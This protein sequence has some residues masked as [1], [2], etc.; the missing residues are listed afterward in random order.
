MTDKLMWPSSL[1]LK[2]LLK[3]LVGNYSY[4]QGSRPESRQRIYF[5]NHTSHLD[6]VAIWS[7]LPRDLRQQTKPVAAAD[8]WG[9][10]ALRRH[11]AL[12]TMNAVL[13]DRNVKPSQGAPL[14]SLCETLDAGKSLIIFPEGTRRAQALPSE[15]KGG[16]Y[17]LAKSYPQ[18]ELIPVYVANLHRS[19]PKGTYL[20]VPITCSLYF[21]EAI[22]LHP[23][24]DKNTFLQRTRQAI[25][26]LAQ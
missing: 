21:G 6:T 20:P 19:M 22:Q 17:H 5:A 2:W 23:D 16:L 14:K 26:D 8:Y 13:L 3:L 12:R 24:E 11:I 10:T 1:L 7:A 9:K 15:F 18:V 4:W 25:V